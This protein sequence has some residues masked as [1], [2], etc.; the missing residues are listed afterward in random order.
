MNELLPGMCVKGRRIPGCFEPFETAVRAVLGQQIS[1]KAASTLAGRMAQDLGMAVETGI[2]G[3]NHIFPTVEA[4]IALGGR[5]QE[6]LGRLGITAAR[7]A[8]IRTLAEAMNRGEIQIEQSAAPEQE[9][10]KLQSLKG[11]GS[12]TAQYIAMRTMGWT[13]AFLETD[14]GVKHALPGYSSKELLA[15][16]ERWKPWRSYAVMNLWG[17]EK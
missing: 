7:S 9:I 2:E 4:I 11:I 17:K 14:A 15:L 6:R 1:V 13:D 5:A 16:A 8:C 10:K 12:W 3:L